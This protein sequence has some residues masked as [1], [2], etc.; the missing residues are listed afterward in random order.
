MGWV[1][2]SET[3]NEVHEAYLVPEFEDGEHGI[4]ISG[5]GT[6][7]DAIAVQMRP[8]CSYRMRPAGE[9]IGWRLQGDR[10]RRDRSGAATRSGKPL[11]IPVPPRARQNGTPHKI[12][13]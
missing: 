1:H 3:R 9:V 4:G 11:R 10:Y 12:Y 8:D 5:G 2:E 7:A 13:P 6:P